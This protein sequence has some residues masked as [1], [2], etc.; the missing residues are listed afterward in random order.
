[1]ERRLFRLVHLRPLQGSIEVAFKTA[2]S[3]QR[4]ATFGAITKPL[5]GF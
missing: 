2:G 1:M 4:T 3:S 5:T